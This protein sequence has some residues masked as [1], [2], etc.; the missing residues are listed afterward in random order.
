MVELRPYQTQAVDD[1][2]TAYCAGHEGAILELGTGAGKTVSAMAVVAGVWQG[3]GSVLWL[4]HRRELVDQARE[5]AVSLGLQP[6][7]DCGKLRMCTVQ[8]S[9]WRGMEPDPTVL[10]ID[11]GHR[12]LAASYRAVIAAYS[13][14]FRV[15]LTGTAWRSDG[16]DFS[17]VAPVTVRGP[18]IGELTDAGWLV[19]AA[20]WSVPG[21]D[22]SGLRVQRGEFKPADVAAAM[23][24]PQLV[25]DVAATLLRLAPGRRGVV[26]CAGVEHALHVAEALVA[27]GVDAAAVHGGTKPTE[28]KALL[29]A[30]R[31]G[32]L[33]VLC[34]ADLL[35]EGW[36][37][38]AVSVV[39]VARATASNIV[40]RQAV[41]RGLRPAEGKADCVVIDH[42]G[43]CARLG[44]VAEA[45]E[46]EAG[47]GGA[48]G[49]SDGL[50]LLTCD[51]CFAVLPSKPRPASCPRC[52][53]LIAAPAGRK[54][55]QV[56]GELVPFDG[57]AA[58]RGPVDWNL[59]RRIDA[60][61]ERKGYRAGWTWTQ[62]AIRSEVGSWATA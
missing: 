43:N 38:P 42:G 24:R 19:P 20:Y 3:R 49:R 5:C 34:N 46:Y 13:L 14:A 50:S 41:G 27:A 17:A 23:D 26:F 29:A 21:A 6:M 15:L 1:L 33:Q 12:A 18:S 16:G 36:D 30:H 35:I 2:R 37:N 54:V 7:L 44:L 56:A 32:S 61:R 52:F 45:L 47:G 9:G 11:E 8:G 40:W 57:K 39:S 55:E 28:R 58:R 53:A 22:L 25:G 60:E 10:V 51:K 62:Y 59:W 48:R 4:A 31:A